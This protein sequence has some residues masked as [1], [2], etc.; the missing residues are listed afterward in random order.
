MPY[1]FCTR[2]ISRAPSRETAKNLQIT[3]AE[4]TKLGFV[5]YQFEARLALGEMEM[6]FGKTP[7]GRA[8]LRALEKD[9]TA[10]GFFLIARKA[11]AAASSQ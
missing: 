3:L 8:R 11:H 5:P 7:A 1:F 10:K 2:A 4:S 9:A 6:R